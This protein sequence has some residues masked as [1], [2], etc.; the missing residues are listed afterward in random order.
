MRIECENCQDVVEVTAKTVVAP[1]ICSVCVNDATPSPAFVPCTNPGCDDCADKMYATPTY[2][3]CD[4]ATVENTT[5]LIEDLQQQ[6]HDE[7]AS[8]VALEAE[9][10]TAK[11]ALKGVAS[12]YSEYLTKQ[13]DAL[14][15]RAK[16]AEDESRGFQ[17]QILN[18]PVVHPDAWKALQEMTEEMTI[19]EAKAKW[20]NFGDQSWV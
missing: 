2:D 4:T 10:A 18:P 14:T 19:A 3:P 6:L 12:A 17:Q 15:T 16:T 11:E 9:L 20:P 5:L 13:I 8:I 1:F 7:R